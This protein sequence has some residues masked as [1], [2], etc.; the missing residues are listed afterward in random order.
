MAARYPAIDDKTGELFNLEARINQCRTEHQDQDA[1]EYESD[2]LLSLTAYV[3]EQSR[4][5]PQTVTIN[6]QTR[7]TIEYRRSL[8][9]APNVS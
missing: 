3:A 7:L 1:F 8:A 2:A 4:R 9:S 5:M 6:D